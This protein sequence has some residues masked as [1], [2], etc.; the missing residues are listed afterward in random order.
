MSGNLDDSTIL[1]GKL[2]SNKIYDLRAQLSLKKRKD[3]I[4]SVSKSQFYNDLFLT[5]FSLI[6][7]IIVYFESEEFYREEIKITSQETKTLKRRNESNTLVT[8]LRIV[9]IA[10]T[11][12]ICN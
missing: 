10:M 12:G 4:Y 1:E 6:S 5:I 7:V 9:N 3:N 2:K 8:A 11:I